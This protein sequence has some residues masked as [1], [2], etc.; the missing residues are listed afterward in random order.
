MKFLSLFLLLIFASSAWSQALPTG[1]S[2]RLEGLTGIYELG[3][4]TPGIGQEMIQ[5]EREAQFLLFERERP[6]T[7]QEIIA[8]RSIVGLGFKQPEIRRL[9]VDYIHSEIDLMSQR[10]KENLRSQSESLYIPEIVV[11]SGPHSAAYLQ[12][13]ASNRPGQ[14]TLVIDQKNRVGGTF[15]DVNEAFYLNSTNRRNE[16]FRAQPGQGDL[17]YVHD[18]VGIP[19]FKARR[20]IEA[21]SLG[22]VAAVGLYLSDAVFMTQTKVI[23]VDYN[24]SNKK[25]TYQV[26]LRDLKTGRFSYVYTDRVVLS[27]GLGKPRVFRDK[28]TQELIER[29]QKSARKKGTAPKLESFTDFVDRIGN[30][31]NR[32]PIRDLAGK[33]VG[34]VG[35]GDSGRVISELLT[36]LGPEGAYRAD[37]AQVGL[38]KRIYWFV[39]SS[40]ASFKNCK[41]YIEKTRARYS[42][43]AQ[44]LNSGVLVPVYSRVERIEGVAGE[45]GKFRVLVDRNLQGQAVSEVGLLNFE[46]PSDVRVGRNEAQIVSQNITFDKIIYSIGFET[47]LPKVLSKL[48]KANGLEFKDAWRK[49]SETLDAFNRKEVNVANV[50]KEPSRPGENFGITLIG[51]SNEVLGGLPTEAEKVGINANSVSLFAG[52]ERTKGIESALT[53]FDSLKQFD[54]TSESARA[55]ELSV[56]S[57]NSQQVFGPLSQSTPFVVEVRINDREVARS[58]STNA[59]LGLKVG[60]ATESARYF[61]RET[62]SG[63]SNLRFSIKA[64]AGA[65]NTL[66]VS[67]NFGLRTGIAETVFK[68]QQLVNQLKRSYFFEGSNIQEVILEV[69]PNAEGKVLP[70]NIKVEIVKRARRL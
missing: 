29:E 32:T 16:G 61:Q 68:N 26:K 21:G 17:N 5:N 37:V 66:I 2:E 63:S 18:I 65:E 47:Q 70:E 9:M 11:G 6:I 57:V 41:E 46:V 19:D 69:V 60:F 45:D 10:L 49:V 27:S 28:P 42:Q 36:G 7:N 39:G 30:V 51:T 43:I 4:D 33:T 25:G 67:S 58:N 35:L 53:R 3:I 56:S 55:R 64:K 12:S 15:A 38:P 24:R 52:I 13:K 23:S 8:A 34:I 59:L 44:A 1:R 62:V 20:W 48:L 50:L 31:N 14:T 40:E 22:E 54:Y